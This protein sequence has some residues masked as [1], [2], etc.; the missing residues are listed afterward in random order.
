MII[1]GYA[2]PSISDETLE[3]WLKR[4]TW[5]SDFSYVIKEDGNILDLADE[6]VIE[7]ADSAGVRPMMVLTSMNNEGMFSEEAAAGIFKNGSAKKMLIDNIYSVIN[8]KGLGGVDFDFEYISAEYA[9]DYAELVMEAKR[10]LSPWGYLTTAALAPKIS[11]EQ[12]GRL[13]EGHDYEKLG[14]ASDYCLLMTYEW[15]YAYGEPMA[16]SPIK[17]V[18]Q[19]VEY[20]LS[21]IP[22]EKLL[23]G[24]NNYGYDW[25]LPV[26]EGE[27]AQTLLAAKAAERAK[28]YGAEIMFDEETASP[29][30]EYEDDGGR[31]HIVWFENERSWKQ[32]IS[33]VSEYGLAGIGIWNIMDIFP[34]Q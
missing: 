28:L 23:L 3:W 20:A 19:V 17:K 1:N 30:Y 26:K 8:E 2:Y 5:V 32:R 21:K 25:A 27:R 14:Q 24:I 22:A 12:K 33:L 18:R 16:V 6:K 34:V 31:K 15:G 29:F 10:K 13:Y 11:D 9:G 7:M 4:L